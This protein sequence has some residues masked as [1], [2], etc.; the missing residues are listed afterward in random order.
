MDKQYRNIFLELGYS[1]AEIDKKVTET[2]RT[3]FEGPEDE[4]IYADAPDNTGYMIDTGNTD[5]RTEGMSYGMMMAVQMDRQDIF[6]RLW[7]WSMTHMF[8]T[9][10]LH[11]G[12]FA[13]SCQLDGTKNAYGPAPDG[14]EYYALALF[15][16]SH[17]WGDRE[18]PFDYETQAKNLLRTCIHKGENDDGYPMWSP[19]TYMIK[20]IPDCEFTDPSYHLPHYYELFAQWAYPED[21]EFWRKA[22]DASR[23][24]IPTACHHVT[25]FAPQYSEYDAT[26]KDLFGAADFYSDSYRVAANIGLDAVWYGQKPWQKTIA[27]NLQRFFQDI[28]LDKY[29][30]YDLDGTPRD[31]PSMHPVGLL[32]TNAQA[33]LATD[34]P[35]AERTVR[36]F[37]DTPLRKGVRRYYDNCLYFFAVLALS[38]NYRIY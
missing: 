25:G 18:A 14:E 1:Q 30:A 33:A 38:G 4:R 5:A 26:P 16:A 2:W 22:A 20:F 7:K 15:F 6:D 35:V 8:M 34:G 29:M 27:D 23:A 36:Q 17:R 3:M 19:V 12:Y 28:P 31:E 9:E 13:W 37:W 11:A 21:R 24:F 32:A 10:G